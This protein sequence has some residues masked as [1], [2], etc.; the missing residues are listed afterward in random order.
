MRFTEAEAKMY[1]TAALSVGLPVGLNFFRMF[2]GVTK[3]RAIELEG[4][5][6]DLTAAEVA[7]IRRQ[8]ENH[9]HR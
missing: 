6:A 7:A 2:K 9:R 4:Y 1:A 8:N 3:K 5:Q